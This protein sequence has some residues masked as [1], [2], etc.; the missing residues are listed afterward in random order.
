MSSV[1]HGMRSGGEGEVAFG[2][3]GG[4][5]G[6]D[7]AEC[8]GGMAGEEFLERLARLALG[9]EEIEQARDGVGDFAGGAAIADRTGDGGDLADT[10]TD[11]EIVGID[12][13]A[14]GLDFFAL[15]A[16]VGDPVLAAGVGA[17]G[18][19]E[20]KLL[21]IIGETVFEFFGEP[22]GE[23]FG[24]GEGEFAEFG[25]G[26]GDGAASE[27]RRFNGKAGGV[28]FG[29]Y[30]GD[31]GFGNVDEEEIL[32]EGVAD[33]AVAIA[34]GETGGEIELRGSDASA[35]DGGANGEEAGL[36]LRDDAEMVAVDLRGRLEGFGGSE[37]KIEVGLQSGEEGA[38]GPAVFEEEEFEAGFFAGL[39][40][41]FAIAEEFG[42]GADDGDDLIPWDE[43][44]ERDGEVRMGGEAAAY[45]QGEAEV[46]KR[47]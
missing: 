14:V 4:A 26:A 27:G 3:F 6:E 37:R 11:A 24:F 15:D 39:A 10:A 38:C 12:H 35:N 22:A 5:A 40:E 19:V 9:V 33:M 21:L 34:L 47:G 41:D 8:V 16:D 36:L 42:D 13:L 32:H 17:A 46:G 2:E 28:E 31:V 23:G 43:R 20:A 1:L 45:T 29:D 30:C 18:D 25:A 44:V 7:G